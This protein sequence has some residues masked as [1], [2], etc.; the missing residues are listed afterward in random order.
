LLNLV[1]RLSMNE[2]SCLLLCP[3][4]T[5]STHIDEVLTFFSFFPPIFFETRASRGVQWRNRKTVG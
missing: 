1:L 5:H 2:P 4:L 3:V